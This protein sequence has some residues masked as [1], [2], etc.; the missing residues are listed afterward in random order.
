MPCT[1]PSASRTQTRLGGSNSNG[2]CDGGNLGLLDQQ[3]ALRR[4]RDNI[5]GFGGNPHN[6]TLFGTTGPCV[7]SRPGL[8][9]SAPC[10]HAGWS[11][12]RAGRSGSSSTCTRSAGCLRVEGR[13]DPVER[14][15]PELHKGRLQQRLNDR[16][17][18]GTGRRE[19]QAGRPAG[20]TGRDPQ[21]GHDSSSP[22]VPATTW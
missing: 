7:M 9:P 13:M 19:A 11:R 20:S 18:P 12:T 21:H 22:C 5:G 2:M 10:W 6:V 4:V 17:S 8:R 16:P 14:R 15:V 3:T 1:A